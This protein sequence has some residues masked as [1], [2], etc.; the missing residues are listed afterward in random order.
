VIIAVFIENFENRM[1]RGWGL[2]IEKVR[3]NTKRDAGMKRRLW[4]DT[5]FLTG[6][7]VIFVRWKYFS[8]LVIER[9]TFP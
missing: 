2:G 8:S 7:R 1:I 5:K 6:K 9:Q 4:P 3:G